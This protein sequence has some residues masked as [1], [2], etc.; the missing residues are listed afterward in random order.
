VTLGPVNSSGFSPTLPG[1]ATQ[2][3]FSSA[4]PVVAGVAGAVLTTQPIFDVEDAWGNLVN[5]SAAVISISSSGGTLSG[6][7]SLAATGGV[8][9]VQGCA[10]EAWLIPLFISLRLRVH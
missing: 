4:T 6:C 2:L 7:S 5:T 1:A 9:T 10:L 3:V 8:V